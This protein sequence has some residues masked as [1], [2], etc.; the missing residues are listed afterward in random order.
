M[1]SITTA[2]SAYLITIVFALVIAAFL[3][4]VARG[5][6]RLNLQDEASESGPA[7]SVPDLAPVAIALAAAKRR[8]TGK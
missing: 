8:A 6:K 7:P 1:T 3:H 4:L 5:I 2:L